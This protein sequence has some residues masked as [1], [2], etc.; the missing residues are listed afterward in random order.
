MNGIGPVEFIRFCKN[1]SHSFPNDMLCGSTRG[2]LFYS[3]NGGAD[4]VNAG[5]DT[6]KKPASLGGGDW[7]GCSAV[8]WAEF[9]V[10]NP[11]RIFVANCPSTDNEPGPI[12]DWSENGIYRSDGL[13]PPNASTTWDFIADKATFQN[14]VD[15]NTHFITPFPIGSDFYIKKIL[16]DTYDENIL[17]VATSYGLFKTTHAC[18]TAV[19]LPLSPGWDL[20]LADNIWDIEIHPGS[21]NHETIYVSFNNQTNYQYV[22]NNHQLSSNSNHVKCSTDG[23]NSWITL[24][25]PNPTLNTASNIMHVSIE[26]SDAFPNNIYMYYMGPTNSQIGNIYRY[27]YSTQNTTQT[28]TQ[29]NPSTHQH[30]FTYGI[31]DPYTVGMG[32][33]TAFAV[34]QKIDGTQTHG[35]DEVILVEHALN[36]TQYITDANGTTTYTDGSPNF[37]N[38]HMDMEGFAFNPNNIDEAWMA[39]HGGVFKSTNKGQDWNGS[40][41][42]VGVADIKYMATAYTNPEL[43]LIGSYHEGVEL[44]QNSPYTT[45]W[46]PEWKSIAEFDGSNV[47]ID[48]KEPDFMYYFDGGWEKSTDGTAGATFA[49]EGLSSDVHLDINKDE[50]NIIYGKYTNYSNNS[51]VEIWRTKDRGINASNTDRF[52]S[53]LSTKEGLTAVTN[54][55]TTLQ[56]VGGFMSFDGYPDLLIATF[57][58]NASGFMLTDVF[59]TDHASDPNI[60]PVND[61]HKINNLGTLFREIRDIKLDPMDPNTIYITY[62]ADWNNPSPYVYKVT[63]F[64]SATPTSIAYS[65]N[66]PNYQYVDVNPLVVEKG[67]DGGMYLQLGTNVYY[68]NNKIYPICGWINFAGDSYPNITGAGLEINYQVNKIRAAIYGR[69]VWESDLQCPDPGPLNITGNMTTDRY[70]EVD[71]V[72]T[73]TET[74]NTGIL[75]YYRSTT[76]ID[77]KPP[78]VASAASNSNF[79]AFIHNCSHPGNS[80][81]SHG[82]SAFRPA[83]EEENEPNKAVINTLKIQPNPNN[84]TFQLTLTKNQKPIGVKKIEVIDMMGRIVWQ[85]GA[86]ASNTFTIDILN[87]SQGIYYVRTIN[88]DGETEMKKLIKE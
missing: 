37:L 17:Y 3:S 50:P 20:L 54:N 13:S 33:S 26:V 42:G 69:G 74:F 83:E 62:T 48:D 19:A 81:K 16:T 32:N 68:T 79:R 34:S 71:G 59:Y 77:L 75:K 36:Y 21:G 8:S 78:F 66:L 52:I 28:F 46:D 7:K 1:Q 9:D 23:G 22:I 38:Y 51:H 25:I 70:D 72:I 12:G 11:Y 40:M 30:P 56:Q 14:A 80:F 60:D 43:L 2:G 47:L 15:Y 85:T 84:G 39:C 61:W 35:L 88:E 5:T 6:W 86:S 76:E 55:A 4:W 82:G 67:S 24:P 18:T 58:N 44:T 27:D 65:N 10:N 31:N 64:R 63:N 45:G 87:C 73:S 29:I 57:I 53:D 41:S 49:Y